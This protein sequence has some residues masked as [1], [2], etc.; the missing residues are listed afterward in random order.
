MRR[1][2]ATCALV[3][4]CGCTLGPDYQRPQIEAP[5]AFLQPSA[6]GESLATLPWWQ[7]YQDPAL[8]GLIRTALEENQDLGA[9]AWRVE[10]A[11]AQLGFT[12]ADEFPSFTYRGSASHTNPSNRIKGQPG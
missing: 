1:S 3:L 2:T 4:A 6:Q 9:A 7:V 12:H 10:E 5:Q 11:R 8:Q